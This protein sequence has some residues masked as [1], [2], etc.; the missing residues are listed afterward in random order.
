MVI[1][2]L[3]Q[4]KFWT[5]LWSL[6]LGLG[7]NRSCKWLRGSFA[8]AVCSNIS[9]ESFCKINYMLV[10]GFFTSNNRYGVCWWAKSISRKYIMLQCLE[11]VRHLLAAL[12]KCCDLDP[13]KQPKGLEDPER[14]ARE[15]V[16]MSHQ[17]FEF[18]RTRNFCS[19][20][21]DYDI[22][23]SDK[24]LHCWLKNQLWL[25]ILCLQLV[26]VK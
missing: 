17:T 4:V 18:Y 16:C 6:A 5:V 11:G 24:Y 12:L 8:C 22:I 10:I 7:L 13:Y 26:L 21:L 9:G 20:L 3:S 2:F 23:I 14:L 25:L 1:F 15:T 19:K